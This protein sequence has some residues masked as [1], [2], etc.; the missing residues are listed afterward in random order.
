MPTPVEQLFRP[1]W[2]YD[3]MGA[4]PAPNLTTLSA[5]EAEL[6][7]TRLDKLDH[8]C[9]C[10]LGSAVA[11][12]A[13]AAYITVLGIGTGLV[14]DSRWISVGVGGMVFVLAAGAGKILGQIRAR[15]QRH[16]LID[17]LHWRTATARSQS[18]AG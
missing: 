18:V 6:V 15:Q 5:E 17:D 11:L 14:A 8:A 13:L 12:M 4:R 10:G 9:G 16:R 7:R 1:P 2:Q 3:R